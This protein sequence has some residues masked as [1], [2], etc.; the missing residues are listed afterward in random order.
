MNYMRL[1]VIGL[2]GLFVAACSK[3]PAGNVGVK[4]YLL[5]QKKGVDHEVLG[6]GRY[7]IG[8]NEELYLFPTFQQNYTWTKNKNEGGHDNNGGPEDESFTF[9]TQEGL[10]INCDIGVSYQ[11]DPTKVSLIFQK[12]RRGVEEITDIFLRNMVRDE[13][14]KAGAR[15]SMSNLLGAGKQRL[16]ESVQDTISANLVDLGVRDF[17]LYLIGEMRLPPNVK[18]A[19]NAKLEATQKA[20]QSENELQR[21]EAEAQKQIADA[22]GKAQ[23][24]L[25]VARA[26]AEANR[27]KQATLTDEL[28]RYEATQ[29]W[30]GV[31]PTMM[32]G[33]VPFINLTK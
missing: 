15:D 17:K 22:E 10:S 4:V 19:I 18:A 30:N 16:I 33:A 25:K 31:L 7:Y 21:A 6:V 2:C 8:F 13:L 29:K 9:Q 1:L 3:V 24:M 28:I 26:E 27:L 11:I 20:Q 23:S 14:N 32:S 12:Y 5:G